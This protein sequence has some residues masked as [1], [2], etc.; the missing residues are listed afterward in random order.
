MEFKTG[1]A[2]SHASWLTRR[3]TTCI[4]SCT[5]CFCKLVTFLSYSYHCLITAEDNEKIELSIKDHWLHHCIAGN[6]L[7]R[8]HSGCQSVWNVHKPTASLS[9]TSAVFL[10]SCLCASQRKLTIFSDSEWDSSPL[11]LETCKVHV[12]FSNPQISFI[13]SRE[14]RTPCGSITYF[15]LKW[16][17]IF[18]VT[19]FLSVIHSGIIYA[20]P[21]TSL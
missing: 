13:D 18:R 20:S 2:M 14:R 21:S 5:F 15:A 17:C 10:K 4:S 11:I 7:T 1:F 8:C 6:C 3:R 9:S 16:M 19:S 12:W